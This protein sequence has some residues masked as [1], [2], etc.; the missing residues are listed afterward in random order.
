M[1]DAPVVAPAPA[2]AAAPA[3]EAAWILTCNMAGPGESASSPNAKRVFRIGRRLFQE[4]KPAE[5]QFGRNLCQ[6]FSCIG[7]P[8]QLQGVISS[9]TLSLTVT[10]DLANHRA[11]WRALGATGLRT[12]SGFCAVKPDK[13]PQDPGA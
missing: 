13:S 5:N 4:W 12:T 6:A 2:P 8:D 9:S 10:L 11:S 1:I 3:A 7:T